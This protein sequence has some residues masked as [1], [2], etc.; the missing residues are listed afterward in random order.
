MLQEQLL[1]QMDGVLIAAAQPITHGVKAAS[2]F[3]SQ[4]LVNQQPQWVGDA[5]IE[6]I[7]T[8]LANPLLP[9][10]PELVLFPAA[11]FYVLW[12]VLVQITTEI[13]VTDSRLVAKQ[14]IFNIRTFKADLSTLGQ[15]DVNQSLL[16]GLLGYGTIHIF[17]RN[18]SGQGSQVEAEGINLPPV[19]DPHAFSTLVD[20][21]RRMWRT[22]SV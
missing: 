3:I 17:T 11:V 7:L 18:W 2:A 16:G 9:K 15:V 20:R 5:N 1:L 22:R 8:F 12:R 21:A 6:K 14:G 4:Y 13:I 10:I 19:A